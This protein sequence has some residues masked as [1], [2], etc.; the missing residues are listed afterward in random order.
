MIMNILN[1]GTAFFSLGAAVFWFISAKGKVPELKNDWAGLVDNPRA[2]IDAVTYSARWNS[3]ASSFAFASTLLLGVEHLQTPS[4]AVKLSS[5]W[6]TWLRN[7]S[8]ALVARRS[9][10]GGGPART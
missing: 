1:Y 5:E 9:P 10:R 4:V 7:E 8:A 6:L 2:L 3:Y